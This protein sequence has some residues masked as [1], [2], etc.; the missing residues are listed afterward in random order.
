MIPGA[1]EGWRRALTRWRLRRCAAVGPGSEARGTIWIHG[2]GAVRLG[3]RVVLD[4]RA[5]P[6]ELHVG[7]GAEIVL[8]D[9][10]HVA[11]GAS[12]EAERSIRVGARARLG[13]FCKILDNH[14]HR[15]ADHGERPHSQPVIVEE[16]ADLGV[17]AIL[18]P[19]AHVGRGT[20]VGPGTVV[21]RRTPDHAFVAGLPATVQRG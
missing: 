14:Y 17:R 1:G 7:P 16:D 11:G 6:I 12:L 18:L 20:A 10:V 2:G 13:R 15:V 3:A 8:G 9:D 5:A 21:T 19:G 4:G